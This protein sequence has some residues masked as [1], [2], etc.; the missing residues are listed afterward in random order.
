[1][2]RSYETVVIYDGT[3]SDDEVKKESQALE[4]L[5]AGSGSVKG[6]NEWGRRDLAYTIGNRKS[7]Y[8]ILFEYDAGNEMPGAIEKQLKLPM[9]LILLIMCR[10]RNIPFIR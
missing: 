7:G 10:F 9:E 2:T 4:K 1:M 5:I 3:L 8:Y 6:V